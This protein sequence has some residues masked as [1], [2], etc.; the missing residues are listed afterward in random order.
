MVILVSPKVISLE[1][2][3]VLAAASCPNI[4]LLDPEA[5][6]SPASGPII[7]LFEPVLNCL[8]L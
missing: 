4:K 8:P 6:A 1:T 5:N 3:V 7:V 2:V